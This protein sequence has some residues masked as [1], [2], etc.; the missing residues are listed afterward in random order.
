MK[1]SS[2]QEDFE[3]SGKDI[4]IAIVLAEF[5]GEIGQQLLQETLNEL[6]KHKTKNIQ[7]VTVPGALEIPIAAQRLIRKNT[8]D[9]IIALGVIIKGETGH[10]DHVSR[11]SVHGL[12]QLALVSETPIISGILTVLNEQQARDR[13]DRGKEY[14]RSAL[15]IIHTLKN[16]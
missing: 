3:F 16:I 1:Q 15:Q 2:K 13:I 12:A 7:L 4:N 8:F 11:E 6:K 5:N 9:V 14:A 10:Y